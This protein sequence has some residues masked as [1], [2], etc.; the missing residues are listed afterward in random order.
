VYVEVFR[1]EALGPQKERIPGGD[2]IQRKTVLD[3]G[4]VRFWGKRWRCVEFSE[5][6][7]DLWLKLER[8]LKASRHSTVFTEMPAIRVSCRYVDH[9]KD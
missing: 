5:L 9:R 6:T 4:A 2:R 8:D 3:S 1:N 7:K